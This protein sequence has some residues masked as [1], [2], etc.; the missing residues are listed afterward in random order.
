[1]QYANSHFCV[2]TLLEEDLILELVICVDELMGKIL[3]FLSKSLV[4]YTFYS[5]LKVFLF[6]NNLGQLCAQKGAIIFSFEDNSQSQIIPKTLIETKKA[7][8]S[9]HFDCHQI[10]CT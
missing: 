7:P 3:Y 4:H 5:S 10:R 6:Q 8:F 1:M 2:T 9:M